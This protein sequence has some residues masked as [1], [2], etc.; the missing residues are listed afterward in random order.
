[1]TGSTTGKLRTPRKRR[2]LR[3]H[4]FL[5]GAGSQLDQR[6]KP[7]QPDEARY[8]PVCAGKAQV[9]S[10]DR[11][12]FCSRLT[13]CGAAG[14][15]L[16]DGSLIATRAR[17]LTREIDDVTVERGLIRSETRYRR[18]GTPIEEAECAS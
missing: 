11:D 8:C 7:R 5:R 4:S 15:V 17:V 3:K 18:D 2:F 16:P 13:E 1:M 6:T 9:R 12:W 10:S 14:I